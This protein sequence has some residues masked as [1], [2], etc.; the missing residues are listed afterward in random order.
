[1]MCKVTVD[2]IWMKVYDPFSY[3]QKAVICREHADL[4]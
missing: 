3:D 4:E 2:D 1:M